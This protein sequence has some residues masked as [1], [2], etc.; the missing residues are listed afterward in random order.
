MQGAQV[1]SLVWELDPQLRVAMLKL[2]IARAATKTENSY[3]GTQAERERGMM[4]RTI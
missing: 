3:T 2:K 4:D 1:Q